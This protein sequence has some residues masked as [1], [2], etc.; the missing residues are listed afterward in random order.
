MEFFIHSIILIFSISL[1][2]AI[3][4]IIFG[5]SISIIKYLIAKLLTL[6]ANTL[7]KGYLA[8]LNKT[9]ILK[10]VDT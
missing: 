4:K 5:C 1:S 7:K 6:I 10:K 9:K 2:I 8:L 3:I